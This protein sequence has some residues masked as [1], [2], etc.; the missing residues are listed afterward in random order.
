MNKT[1]FET[2]GNI[3]TMTR[4]FDAQVVLVWRAWTEAEML[5]QWWAPKPWRS[6]TSHRDFKEG[7]HRIYAM[8]GPNGE[9][10]IGRTDY[11]SIK[12]HHSVSGEDSF[13]DDQG[14]INPDLPVAQFNN[15]F[16]PKSNSTL[17]TLVSEYTSEEHLRQVVEM[18]M[19]EGFNMA[20][21]NLDDLLRNLQ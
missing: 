1:N 9:K 16:E 13:C 19:Q 5:D 20:F 2:N 8:I 4:I 14:N 15:Q 21:N 7:G 17:V 6:E 3:L 10:H 18:G 11:H 12:L